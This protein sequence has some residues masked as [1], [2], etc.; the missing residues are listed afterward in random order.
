MSQYEN[1]GKDLWSNVA[2]LN[3]ERLP[4]LYK[5]MLIPQIAR[6]RN[7]KEYGN[8]L[9]DNIEVKVIY[10]N[11][12]WTFL[13]L[14]YIL[15]VSGCFWYAQIYANIFNRTNWVSTLEI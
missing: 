3:F 10:K 11:L 12:M 1:G 6:A 9:F 8:L 15:H 13:S 4:R 2:T 7:L 14:Y 5:L